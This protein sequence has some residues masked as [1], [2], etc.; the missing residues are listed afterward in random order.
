MLN[1]IKSWLKMRRDRSAQKKRLDQQFK[2]FLSL[3]R[4]VMD[5]YNFSPLN[6]RSLSWN[7][8]SKG[9]LPFDPRT[10]TPSELSISVGVSEPDSYERRAQYH[11]NYDIQRRTLQYRDTNHYNYG[12]W[13][14]VPEA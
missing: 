8:E 14:D 9:K 5:R 12:N 10:G 11:Y 3:H 4:P 6:G 1:L 2:D 13:K 7:V